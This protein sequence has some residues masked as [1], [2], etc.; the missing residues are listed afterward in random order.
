MKVKKALNKGMNLFYKRTFLNVCLLVLTLS[1]GVFAGQRL[2]A[3][4]DYCMPVNELLHWINR[5]KEI[6]TTYKE[7]LVK[8]LKRHVQNIEEFEGFKDPA[9]E[10]YST[11]VRKIFPIIHEGCDRDL[12][13]IDDGAYIEEFLEFY[14]PSNDQY[15]SLGEDQREFIDMLY[16]CFNIII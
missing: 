11:L 4:K 10:G 6:N 8:E 5:S 7:A 2:I 15:Q 9:S 13:K 12:K 14:R 16:K 3:S 1:F